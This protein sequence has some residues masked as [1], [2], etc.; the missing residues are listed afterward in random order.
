MPRRPCNTHE[1]QGMGPSQMKCNSGSS[2]QLAACCLRFFSHSS[3][4][5]M[6]PR[7]QMCPSE[8]GCGGGATRAAYRLLQLRWETRESRDDHACCSCAVLP[9]AS[10]LFQ[11]VVQ[12]A[13]VKL[14]RPRLALH[15]R[16]W[17]AGRPVA[18]ISGARTRPP[19]PPPPPPR[20]KTKRRS[21]ARSLARCRRAERAPSGRRVRTRSALARD[22][23]TRPRY[24]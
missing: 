1:S 2:S 9:R 14:F 22:T 4:N 21:L 13:R 17:P 3:S 11:F 16:Q 20:P 24:L 23:R 5:E 10:A 18:L 15:V 8:V 12:R 7:R 6:E 19:P